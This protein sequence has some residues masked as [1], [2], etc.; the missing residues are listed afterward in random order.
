MMMAQAELLQAL[1]KPGQPNQPICHLQRGGQQRP[2][3]KRT[4]TA[5][6][7][8]FGCCEL[9]YVVAANIYDQEILHQ[10]EI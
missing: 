1:M 7:R 10:F 4:E 2:S 5:A 6:D 9:S 3:R 8:N